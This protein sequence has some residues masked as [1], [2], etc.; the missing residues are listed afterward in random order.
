MNQF[1]RDILNI[2]KNS[3]LKW[4][5]GRGQGGPKPSDLG[6]HEPIDED[7]IV[8][9]P[10]QIPLEEPPPGYLEWAETQKSTEKPSGSTVIVINMG[11]EDDE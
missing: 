11:D 8:Q 10:L 6:E 7:A 3:D 9:I 4:I 2:I 1:E 5:D